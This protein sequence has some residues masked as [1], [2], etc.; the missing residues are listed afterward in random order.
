LELKARGHA[1]AS[2][3]TQNYSRNYSDCWDWTGETKNATPRKN[4]EGKGLGEKG[5]LR[6]GSW[7]STSFRALNRSTIG[8]AGVLG[9]G[10]E[11][12]KEPEGSRRKE[13]PKEGGDKGIPGYGGSKQTNLPSKGGKTRMSETVNNN[14]IK[15]KKTI[16][17]NPSYLSQAI[18]F[19][20]ES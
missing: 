1:L 15:E 13:V 8:F 7:K 14:G 4:R 9:T 3:E 20:K 19:R 16:H 11:I 6:T 10:T 18:V 12:K 2:I 17:I 5:G